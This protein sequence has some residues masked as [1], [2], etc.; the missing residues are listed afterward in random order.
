MR[1]L[2]V[3]ALAAS[4]LT[5]PAVATA[6]VTVGARL[7]YGMVAGD[8][9][10]SVKMSSWVDHEIP[11]QV[12]ASFRLSPAL[13]LGG[14]FSYGFGTAAS[15]TGFDSASERRF[16][17]QAALSFMPNETLSPWVGA[18]T[19]WAWLKVT[20]GGSEMTLDGWEM[21]TVQGGVDYRLGQNTG[22]GLFASYA[23]GKY[24]N[25]KIT[26][27]GTKLA[28]GSIGTGEQTTHGLFTLGVRGTF[29]L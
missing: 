21:L 4:A 17:V 1:R 14:Y 16:G 29:D 9:I 26:L 25:G 3:A 7:G 23:A 28:S 11:V 2:L 22:L 5:L 8:A 20:G 18:A 15:G 27:A 19:G 13:H 24:T 12:D 6:Q 10:K